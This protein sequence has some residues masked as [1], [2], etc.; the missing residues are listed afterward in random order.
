MIARLFTT[1]AR[2]SGGSSATR[3][4]KPL[5]RSSRAASWASPGGVFGPYLTGTIAGCVLVVATTGGAAGSRI[6]PQVRSADTEAT[7]KPAASAIG[8]RN[9]GAAGDCA[10]RRAAM[11]GHR[12]RA[13]A[14]SVGSA[15]AAAI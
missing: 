2:V 14:T 9:A 6:R 1:D 13:G 5:T 15:D 12:S 4:L 8:Q 11:P 10:S 7:R 3:A